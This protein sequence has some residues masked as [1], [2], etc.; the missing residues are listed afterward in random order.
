MND[1]D[2]D[3]VYECNVYL[4]RLHSYY[5]NGKDSFWWA[6][7]ETITLSEIRSSVNNEEIK[8]QTDYFYHDDDLLKNKEWHIGRIKYFIL[9]PIEIRDIVV[10]DGMIKDGH[11]RLMAA[12]AREDELIHISYSGDS[13]VFD[14][15]I[16]KTDKKPLN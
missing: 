5:L 2:S 16:G 10:V 15:L 7:K 11:H 3:I 1:F 8:I 6:N 4:E 14:Y 9:N 12:L 13:T